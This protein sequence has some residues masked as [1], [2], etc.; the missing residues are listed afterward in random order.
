MDPAEPGPVPATPPRR[1]ALIG[2]GWRGIKS[3]SGSGLRITAELQATLTPR[4]EEWMGGRT[5]GMKS[6][7]G[8]MERRDVGDYMG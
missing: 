2:V 6:I 5:F 7:P 4:R 8:A 1:S 3:E